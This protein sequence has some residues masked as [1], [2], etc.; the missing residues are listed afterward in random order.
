MQLQGETKGLILL[1]KRANDS[2]YSEDDIEY[3]YSVGSLAI[4]SMKIRGYSKKH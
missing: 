4:V 1:G 2:D 3:I